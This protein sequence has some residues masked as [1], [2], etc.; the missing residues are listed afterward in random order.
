MDLS[1]QQLEQ[2]LS[3]RKQISALEERLS[4][5]FGGTTSST[6]ARRSGGRRSAGRSRRPMS[7]A[8]RAKLAAAARARWA[9]RKGTAPA[10][11]AAKAP[12]RKKGLTAAG[13]RRLSES[14]K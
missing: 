3:I 9:R 14:M 10:A 11:P 1:L 2:A 8:T 13:R 5:L 7:P 6:V 4:A 12:G